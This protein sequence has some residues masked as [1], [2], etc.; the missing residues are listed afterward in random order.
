MHRE[1]SDHTTA[2]TSR[3]KFL[4]TGTAL[5]VGAA[6]AS[7]M[8][9]PAFGFHNSV[10]DSIKVGLVGCGGRGTGALMNVIEADSCLLYTSPSPRDR[11]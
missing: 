6:A 2:E 1:P 5:S 10:D 4:A 7:A 11:G 8:P 9:R 3:R